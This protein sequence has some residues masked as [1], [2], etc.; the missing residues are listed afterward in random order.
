GLRIAASVFD[1]SHEA[2]LITDKHNHI[3]DVNPAFSRIT[4]Y[5]REEVLGLNPNILSSGRHSPEYY[6]SMWQSIQQNDFWRGELW[7]RRKNG[8][9]YVELLSVSRV[10]LE[11]PGQYFHVASFSDITAL[12]NHARELDRA[13]NYDE[14]TGLPN[15]QLLVERLRTARQ[16]A[17]RQKRT[18]QSRNEVTHLFTNS[19]VTTV[20][21]VLLAIEE[22]RRL[23]LAFEGHRF[24][25]LTRTNRA[26]E[27]LGSYNPLLKET[28]QWVFP[29]PA[30]SVEKDPG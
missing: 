13:A 11:E 14:L 22:E 6:R 12:K 23:E 15:R 20:G 16:H 21:D 26:A 1:R 19:A 10:H 3:M 30:S 8:E 25:D 2:I 28:Y 5:S 7:N 9:E 18:I 29:I 27:V 4:G 24:T 17:D